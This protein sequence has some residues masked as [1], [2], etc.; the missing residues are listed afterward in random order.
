MF[1]IVSRQLDALGN[2]TTVYFDF[3]WIWSEFWLEFNA[4]EDLF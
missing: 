3:T 4:T 1:K 2:N